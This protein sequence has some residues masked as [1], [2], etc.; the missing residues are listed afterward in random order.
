[1]LAACVA[2]LFAVSADAIDAGLVDCQVFVVAGG[3]ASEV[4]IQHVARLALSAFVDVAV[5]LGARLVARIA[6]L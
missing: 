4:F 1:L 5:A 3:L 2:R 6:S